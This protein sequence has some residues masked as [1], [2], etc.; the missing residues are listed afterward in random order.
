MI[1]DNTAPEK[2]LAELIQG[3]KDLLTFHQ[4]CGLDYPRS[5]ALQC[6][7]EGPPSAATVYPPPRRQSEQYTGQAN[8]TEPTTKTTAETIRPDDLAAMTA[9]YRACGLSEITEDG[10]AA[11]GRKEGPIDLFIVCDPPLNPG[12]GAAPI[13]GE[14]RELLVKM[15]TAID[16][17]MEEVYLTSIVKC[18][19]TDH[20]YPAEQGMK[21]CLAR[22]KREVDLLNPRLILTLGPLS[23]RLMLDTEKQLFTM[24]GKLQRWQD[25]TLIPSYH[26]NMLLKHS[27]LK[28]ASWKDLR[29][30]KKMLTN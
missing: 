5:P 3:T 1:D 9:E 7:L 10:I 28:K 25:T 4:R 12:K 6:F 21:A 11:E 26:P 14:D 17:Q 22:L 8:T 29:L 19:P 20:D 2:G 27:E 13:Q 16:M 30:I 23:A 15:L 18:L 24:R